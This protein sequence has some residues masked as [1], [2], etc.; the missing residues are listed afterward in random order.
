MFVIGLGSGVF[1][2]FLACLLFDV[3]V[4]FSIVCVVYSVFLLN[5]PQTKTTNPN[6]IT[7]PQENKNT[8]KHT[9]PSFLKSMANQTQKVLTSRQMNNVNLKPVKWAC[10]VETM[11]FLILCVFCVIVL[12]MCFFSGMFFGGGFY[13][14]FVFCVAAFVFGVFCYAYSCFY[15][16]HHPLRYSKSGTNKTE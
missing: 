4:V 16:P 13:F 15:I 14:A 2:V 9:N 12:F 6:G 10:Q 5:T 3:F 1:F 7:K 8:R 11:V